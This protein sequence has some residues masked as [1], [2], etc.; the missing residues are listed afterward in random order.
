MVSDIPWIIKN[1]SNWF[2]HNRRCEIGTKYCIFS[3]WR[4]RDQR[5]AISRP[6]IGVISPSDWQ[7]RDQRL[8]LSL[9][10]IGNIAISDWRY[11]SQ[12]LTFSTIESNITCLSIDVHGLSSWHGMLSSFSL[13]NVS[14]MQ[15]SSPSTLTNHQTE[16]IC[17]SPPLYNLFL[18]TRLLHVTL[19]TQQVCLY[20]IFIIFKRL[21]EWL[22]TT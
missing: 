2:D 13:K 16:C 8:A 21:Q 22:K 20:V 18:F 19:H 17:F 11:L 9:P 15:S 4:Y 3:A 10:A 5:L 14:S 6:A 7:Y 12:R 1:P